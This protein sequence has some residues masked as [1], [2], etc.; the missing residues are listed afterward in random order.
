MQSKHKQTKC[1]QTKFLQ[2]TAFSLGITILNQ[3]IIWKDDIEFV[4]EFQC[5]LGHPVVARNQEYKETDR[6]NFEKPSLRLKSHPFWVTLHV[7]AYT[8][9]HCRKFNVQCTVYSVQ[10]TGTV[11]SVQSTVYRYS[12][13]VQYAGW[14]MRMHFHKI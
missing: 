1:E 7:L 11:Y 6:I 14:R 3:R 5:L 10:C 2:I 8:L 4:T 12:V 9:I 13:Q